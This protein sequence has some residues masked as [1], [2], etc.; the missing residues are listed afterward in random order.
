MKVNARIRKVIDV[1]IEID[2][3]YKPLSDD[4]FW[5]T[6]PHKADCL[7]GEMAIDIENREEDIEV[8]YVEDMNGNMLFEG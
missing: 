8:I 5:V 6:N 2:D 3:K 7:S 4:A 1:E